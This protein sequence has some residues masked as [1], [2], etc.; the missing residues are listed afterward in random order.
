MAGGRPLVHLIDAPVYV[1]RAYHSL[2]P[3]AAPNGT[4]TQAANDF[5]VTLDQALPNKNAILFWGPQQ[6]S[7]PFQNGMLCVGG[8]ITRGTLVNT[9]G[10]GHAAYPLPVDAGML[11][12]QRF[13]QWWFRDPGDVLGTGLSDGLSVFFCP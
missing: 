3:M 11:G 8:T 13:H 9:D 5:V 10:Q 12:T 6:K 4:P 1:F 7:T 2:P